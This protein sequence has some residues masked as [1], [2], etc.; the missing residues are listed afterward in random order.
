MRGQQA[1]RAAG[2]QLRWAATHPYV[3][4][5]LAASMVG[6][7]TNPAEVQ[8]VVTHFFANAGDYY[9]VIEL[10][11]DA[12]LPGIPFV[13]DLLEPVAEFVGAIFGSA[14]LVK[15]VRRRGYLRGGGP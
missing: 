15:M 8:Q 2:R 11:L 1:L 7:S 3:A 5:A 9:T 10:G 6:I 14:V 13:G 4:A 12:V